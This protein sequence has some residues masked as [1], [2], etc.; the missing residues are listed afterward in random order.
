MTWCMSN[1]GIFYSVCTTRTS[2]HDVPCRNTVKLLDD[3][4]YHL[5]VAYIKDKRMHCTSARS[6]FNS[7][8]SHP[9]WKKMMLQ[10]LF[11]LLA[12]LFLTSYPAA[13]YMSD[14]MLAMSQA[15]KL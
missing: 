8:T 15:S 1:A 11:V 12:A 13:G 14:E 6:N 10:F 7:H 3:E 4:Q 9:N 5:Q 2:P